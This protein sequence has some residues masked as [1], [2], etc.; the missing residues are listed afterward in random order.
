LG[1]RDLA[2]DAFPEPRIFRR[3]IRWDCEQRAAN[4]VAQE[5]DWAYLQS[6]KSIANLRA[7]Q[8]LLWI[9]AC[10]MTVLP[11]GRQQNSPAQP[12][13]PD[14]TSQSRASPTA[15][16]NDAGK[17]YDQALDL[18]FNYP[19]EM[20]VLDADADME[21]GHINIFGAPGDTDPEHIKSKQCT[22]TLLDA[23][24]S[25]GYAPERLAK[26]DEWIDDTQEYKDSRR[27]EPISGKILIVE[28]RQECI[29]KKER[30]NR[31]GILGGM[32][33]GFVSLPGI[34]R[35]PRPL[36][37]DVGG[38]KLHMNSG[39]GRPI[40]N[41]KLASAPTLIMAMAGE[42]RGHLLAWVFNCN[43]TQTFNEMTKS[44]VK[45]GDGA[46]AVMFPPNIG[47]KGAGTPMKISPN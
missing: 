24:L 35:Q 6:M 34:Q 11:A 38:Q 20:R 36:W 37:F 1:G 39:A 32:A 44:L 42:W 7:M 2:R 16:G 8:T 30:K 23:Q 26:M 33:L 27:P 12:Q 14:Q 18:H 45:F 31:D 17:F 19:I 40:I 21:S 41:G 28:L 29:P 10:F 3:N 5:R 13:P 22:R 9:L 46:W 4:S 47:P 15:A 25:E 43:D